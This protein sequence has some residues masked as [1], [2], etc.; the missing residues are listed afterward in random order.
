MAGG[1]GGS[2]LAFDAFLS[3]VVFAFRPGEDLVGLRLLLW[4]L[5]GDRERDRRLLPGLPRAGEAER[6]RCLK[7]S[8]RCKCK[9]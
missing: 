6:E 3:S 7:Y 2:G 9:L 5:A 4:R 1:V 8:G